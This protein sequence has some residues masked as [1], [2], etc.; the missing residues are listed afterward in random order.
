MKSKKTLEDLNPQTE[1]VMRWG[2][3]E[4][5]VAYLDYDEN[6]YYLWFEPTWGFI[7]FCEE[8]G[9][10]M[11]TMLEDLNLELV[12]LGVNQFS[13]LDDVNAFCKRFCGDDEPAEFYIDE[14]WHDVRGA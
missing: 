11:Q 4:E 2:N 14:L 5:V 12:K 3:G 7:D 13:D 6:W 10:T 9:G 8:I 1:S